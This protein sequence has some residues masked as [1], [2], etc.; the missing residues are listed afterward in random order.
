MASHNT[1][2]LL[3]SLAAYRWSLEQLEEAI[4]NGHWSQ[5]EKELDKTRALR[6]GFLEPPLGSS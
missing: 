4:I 6:P 3:K 5:L 1:S 2:A